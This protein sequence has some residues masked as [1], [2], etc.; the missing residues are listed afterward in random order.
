MWGTPA[1]VLLVAELVK[2][3]RNTVWQCS[4]QQSERTDS[5]CQTVTAGDDRL[6]MTAC[7]MTVCVMTK[8]GESDQWRD[9]RTWREQ[10][11]A[12]VLS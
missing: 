12:A 10:G 11:V 2:C 3:H 5:S 1:T 8:R 7:V 9:V 4:A 6:W